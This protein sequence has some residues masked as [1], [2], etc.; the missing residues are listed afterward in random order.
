MVAPWVAMVV[1][2]SPAPCPRRGCYMGRWWLSMPGTAGWQGGGPMGTGGFGG[3]LTSSLPPQ[4][5]AAERDRWPSPREAD[6]GV[7]REH[8][9]AVSPMYPGVGGDTPVLRSPSLTPNPVSCHCPP[10][11]PQP[12]RQ[13]PGG[14]GAGRR[15]R[16]A[17]AA[18]APA[19]AQLHAGRVFPALHQG[20]AGTEHPASRVGS[21]HPA[22]TLPAPGRATAEGKLCPQHSSSWLLQCW[23]WL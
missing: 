11:L 2:G 4:S 5:P 22:R 21:G 17:A 7:G 1:G 20:G 8:Q 6:G 10:A 19:A 16:A 3:H 23:G 14:G 18:S 15:E 12:F 13:H 9:R